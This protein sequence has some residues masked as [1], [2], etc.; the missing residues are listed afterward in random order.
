MANFKEDGER[1]GALSRNDK[2]S[3]KGV[4]CYWS[5]NPGGVRR[6]RCGQG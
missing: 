4:S 6:G 1:G 5:S 2:S 3:V